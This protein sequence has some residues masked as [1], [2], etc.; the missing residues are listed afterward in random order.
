LTQEIR[1]PLKEIHFVTGKGGVGKSTY[2]VILANKLAR[3]GKKTLLVE[4]GRRSFYSSWLKKE[5]V[6]GPQSIAKNLEIAHWSAI[7][8]LKSYVLSLV[9]LKSLNNLFFENPVSRSLIHVA[10]SLTEI[11]IIGQITAA[12]RQ[13]GPFGDHQALVVDGYAT[14]HFLNLVLSP[15]M[16]A[17]TIHFGALNN[18]CIKMNEILRNYKLCRAHIVTGAEDFAITET[19]ELYSKLL[20]EL[21]WKSHIVLNRFLQTELKSQQLESGQSDLIKT[22]QFKLQEQELASEKILK[23]DSQFL[24]IP[25]FKNLVN[26]ENFQKQI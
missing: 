19:Q 5:V 17:E 12:P 15:Q 11:S 13:H 7:E 4:I 6:Y 26:F 24:K 9:K 18:Q 14:G 16:L 20:K 22:I 23:M 3:T 21:N 1:G 25:I 8:C 10:P 2:A